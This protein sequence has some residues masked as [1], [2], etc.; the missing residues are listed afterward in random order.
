MS[1]IFFVSVIFLSQLWL[2]SGILFHIMAFDELEIK[3][4]HWSIRVSEIAVGALGSVLPFAF[5]NLI[6]NMV[7]PRCLAVVRSGITSVKLDQ[8]SAEF[9]QAIFDIVLAG[10]AEET[11]I[12]SWQVLGLTMASLL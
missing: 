3:T 8:S 12:P 10:Q 4:F 6:M 11:K 7:K 2:Y 5:K 1:R 9:L